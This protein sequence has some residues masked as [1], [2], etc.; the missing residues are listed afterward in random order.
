MK[1]QLVI[2]GA[3]GHAKVIA[4][5]VCKAAEFELL[6]FVDAHLPKG[7]LV[8]KTYRVIE[9]QSLIQNLIDPNTYF[10]FG[11]GNNAIRQKL[12]Q[13]FQKDLQFAS[14]LHPSSV[15]SDEVTIG[16]G[17]VVLAN[18]VINAG[19]KV[20]DF[21][22]VDSGVVIDHECQIGNFCHVNV[23][24]IV[25]S[26]SELVTGVKTDLGEIIPNFSKR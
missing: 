3:G 2:I 23:G 26:N 21:S 18:A 13:D 12:A 25:G 4:D 17:T 19:S 11:I 8:F 7:T 16:K 20:G 9:T 10:V 6:G 22:I 24:T 5:A 15:V 14:I 1:K